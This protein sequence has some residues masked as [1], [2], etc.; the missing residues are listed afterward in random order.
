MCSSDLKVVRGRF[1]LLSDEGD[2]IGTLATKDGRAWGLG[3]LMRQRK[4]KVGDRIVVTLDLEKRT[5]T[6][7]MGEDATA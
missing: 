3:S 2:E 1:I 6:V 7:T 5:A 4:A